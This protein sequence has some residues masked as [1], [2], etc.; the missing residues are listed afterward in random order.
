VPLFRLSL[1]DVRLS[2]EINT[3]SMLLLLPVMLLMGMLS[4][5]IGRKPVLLAAT[6]LA[7]VTPPFRP[8]PGAS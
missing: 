4:D 1:S 2:L 8:P 7:F 6:G 3:V 5:R